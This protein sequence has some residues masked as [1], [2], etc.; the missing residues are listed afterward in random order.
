MGCHF[1]L[2]GNFPT[3]GSNWS[4]LHWQADS[5]PLSHHG[6]PI[7]THCTKQMNYAVLL[8]HRELYSIS[9][10]NLQCKRIHTHTHTYLNHFPLCLKL[11]QR[12]F[13][14]FIT[15][16]CKSTM[17][18]CISHSV[19]SNSLQFHGLYQPGSTVRGILQARE[20]PSP[21]DFLNPGIK[22]QVSH[23]AGRFFTI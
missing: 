22:P 1:L 2:Q 13:R 20:F 10:N 9:C 8:Q 3:Q 12:F 21:G 18:V 15:Q 23:T 17:C 7:A 11:T 6:C 14:L 4:L 16:L 19:M 5:S